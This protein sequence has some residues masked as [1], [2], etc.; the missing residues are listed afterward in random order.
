M[1]DVFR[2]I[3]TTCGTHTQKKEFY[4]SKMNLTGTGVYREVPGQIRA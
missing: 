2:I 4:L 1:G 3:P